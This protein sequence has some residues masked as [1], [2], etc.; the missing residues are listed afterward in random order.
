MYLLTE[1]T[2]LFTNTTAW[3]MPISRNLLQKITLLLKFSVTIALVFFYKLCEH[4]G[5]FTIMNERDDAVH[6]CSLSYSSNSTND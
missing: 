2:H 3:P 5:G 6:F 4:N 1:L